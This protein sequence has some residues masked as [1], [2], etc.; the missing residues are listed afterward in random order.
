MFGLNSCKDNSRNEIEKSDN[1]SETVDSLN[2]KDLEEKEN[3]PQTSCYRYESSKDTIKLEM[4]RTDDEEV[5]GS[6]SYNYLEQPKSKGSFKGRIVGDTIF[7]DYT[8]DLKGKASIR[9]L[10][11]IK[12]DSS[13]VEGFGETEEVKGKTKFKK[14]AILSF[15]EVISLSPIDCDEE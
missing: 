5:T 7:A 2:S 8:F 4:T 3:F 12:K 6:L 10:I 14:D 13:L 1:V 9:E 11:F 15:N